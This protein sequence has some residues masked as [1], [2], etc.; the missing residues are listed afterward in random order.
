MLPDESAGARR[1]FAS[2]VRRNRKRAG[3]ELAEVGPMQAIA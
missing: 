1:C 3:E 2:D